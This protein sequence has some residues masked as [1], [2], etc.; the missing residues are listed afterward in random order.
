MT[1]KEKIEFTSGIIYEGEVNENGKPHGY[2]NQTHPN[3]DTYVGE[4]KEG[5][6]HGQGRYTFSDDL[7]TFEGEFNKGVIAKATVTFPSGEKYVGE[8]KGFLLHGY[9]IL[10]H[11]DGEIYEGEFNED[12]DHHGYGVLTSVDGVKQEGMWHE[13]KFVKVDESKKIN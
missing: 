6:P 5:V 1:K 8:L 12:G 9:G 2:G 4:Y 11:P 7:G 10:T 13:G 3:G